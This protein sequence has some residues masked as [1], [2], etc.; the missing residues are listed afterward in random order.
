MAGPTERVFAGAPFA[1]AGG[2]VIS[3]P[4]QF[5]TT[6]EDNLRVTCANTVAGARIAIQGRRLNDK[7]TIEAF[8]FDLVPTADRTLT[9]RDYPLGAGAILNLTVYASAGAPRIGQTFVQAKLIR[10]F[11]GATIVLGTLLAGYVTSLQELAW[12]GSPIESSIA[13]GGYPRVIVGTQPAA[14]AE[15][16]ETVPTGARWQLLGLRTR[17]TASAAVT[18]RYPA[19]ALDDGFS[20]YAVAPIP[21]GVATSQSVPLAWHPG[22]AFE[23][24]I[25]GAWLVAGLPT[26]STLLAGY[27]ILFVTQNLLAGDQYDQPRFLVREWL[28]VN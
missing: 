5:V 19:L 15:I 14:G 21:G 1:A 13:G 17:L 25:A 24:Q 28:E 23:T 2:R 20:N 12:P 27:R 9:T 8:G 4:F 11:G 7:G 18:I 16:I 22:T 26:D 6:G 3:S 10:G